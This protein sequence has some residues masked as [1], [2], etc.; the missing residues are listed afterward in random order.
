MLNLII[1]SGVVG[2]PNCFSKNILSTTFDGIVEY[3][4]I[5][6]GLGIDIGESGNGPIPQSNNQPG[7]MSC[8][9]YFGQLSNALSDSRFEIYRQVMLKKISVVSKNDYKCDRIQIAQR[10]SDTSDTPEISLVPGICNW[11]E[12]NQ[13]IGDMVNELRS[14]SLEVDNSKS[15]I[16]NKL[17]T[18]LRELF[19]DNIS[20][21]FNL[22]RNKLNCQ[23]IG[24]SLKHLLN[25]QR[26]QGGGI[27]ELVTGI[28]GT[29]IIWTIYG[30]IGLLWIIIELLIWRVWLISESEY[31]T[32][33]SQN[34]EPQ[35]VMVQNS[36]LSAPS[37]EIGG[38]K[39]QVVI[40]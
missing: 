25:G 9:A 10:T 3:Y 20:P 19:D 13:Y 16:G 15:T 5:I 6:N 36:V 23:F 12:W 18:D 17:S 4:N 34:D 21:I 24:I 31:A 14:A 7:D 26:S 2:V 40:L 11:S 39:N 22:F 28:D 33:S 32:S 1:S 38:G 35:F 30:L 37:D 8:L 29:S 27:Y